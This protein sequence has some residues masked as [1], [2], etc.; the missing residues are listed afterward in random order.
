MIENLPQL[1]KDFVVVARRFGVR[2]IW[3]DSLCII[4]DSKED[5]TVEAPTMRLVYTN[6]VVNVAASAAEDVEG[7]LFRSRDRS[8]IQ[9]GIVESS[10][11]QKTDVSASSSAPAPVSTKYH[12]ISDNYWSR[13]I[14]MG[15]LHTRAWVYQE[16]TLAPRV[17]HFG[18][19]QILWECL[20]SYRCEAFSEGVAF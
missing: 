18:G 5:W 4:Q 6:S 19:N 1:V 11:F 8:S 3:I 20:R 2:Y 16:R 14:L 17:L 13:E 15:P 10:V 9:P 7:S 12:M